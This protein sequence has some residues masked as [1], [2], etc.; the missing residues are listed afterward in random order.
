[1]AFRT[2]VLSAETRQSI[3]KIYLFHQEA[4]EDVSSVLLL[5]EPP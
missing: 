4:E 3:R 5:E 1:V 2:A